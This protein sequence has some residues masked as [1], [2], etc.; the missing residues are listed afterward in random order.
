[1]W[2]YLEP[3]HAL[4]YFTPAKRAAFADAGLKGGWMGYFASRAAAMGPVPAEVVIATFYNFHPDMVRRA[5]PD[6]WRLSSPERVLRARYAAA[7]TALR[8][9]LGEL[10]NGP[11]VEEAA[12]LA[13]VVAEAGDPA[14]RPL[15]AAHASLEW[16]SEPHMQLWHAATLLREHRGDGHVS[17]L[18]GE[19]IGGCESHVT[20]VAA[21]GSTAELQREYRGWSVDE[22]DAAVGRLRERGLVDG[23]GAFTAEGRALRDRIE[24]HTDELAVGPYSALDAAESARLEELLETIVAR[25]AGGSPVT[26]PNP[27]G[28]PRR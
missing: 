13:R 5:I 4:I 26:F 1:M 19:S 10:T 6:A 9:A 3:Y 12:A 14:G 23:A 25:L 21:G 18:V 22:W 11:D 8:D 27:M 28:L 17:L 20:L 7:D 24:K 16:P 2:Q 15:F